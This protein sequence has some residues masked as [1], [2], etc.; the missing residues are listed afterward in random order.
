MPQHHRDGPVYVPPYHH[1]TWQSKTPGF[2]HYCSS[3]PCLV[4]RS[5]WIGIDRYPATEWQILGISDLLEFQII[6]RRVAWVASSASL[7]TVHGCL[8]TAFTPYKTG[9]LCLYDMIHQF[10]PLFRNIKYHPQTSY[11]KPTLWERKMK[12][13]SSHTIHFS[14]FILLLEIIWHLV[15]CEQSSNSYHILLKTL[16]HSNHSECKMPF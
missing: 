13:N 12:L 9:T 3:P 10:A 14:I 5:I 2:L 1:M 11:I 6:R 16:S 7:L 4:I 8:W 15:N